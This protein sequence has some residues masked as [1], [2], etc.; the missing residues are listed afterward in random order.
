MIYL[1]KYFLFFGGIVSHVVFECFGFIHEGGELGYLLLHVAGVVLD[2]FDVIVVI[3]VGDGE[4]E[5]GLFLVGWFINLFINFVN[6]GVVLFI[7]HV[8][9]GK[10]LNLIIWSRRLNEELVLYF[11]GVGWKLFIVEGNDFEYMYHEMVKVFD[12]SVELIK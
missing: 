4:L 10:I 12:V 7:L 11:I 9:G 8:N 6:D 3:V 2:N 1:F 5:I